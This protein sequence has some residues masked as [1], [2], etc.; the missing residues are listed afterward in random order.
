LNRGGATESVEPGVTGWLAER[1][2]PDAFAEAMDAARHHAW[3]PAALAARADR[4]GV[5]RF[6]RDLSGLVDRAL[7]AGPQRPC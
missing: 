3:D 4:F 5:S 2:T 6:D 7:A 1:A